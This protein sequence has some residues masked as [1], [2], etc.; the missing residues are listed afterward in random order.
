MDFV[1]VQRLQSIQM[2]K[3]EATEK[4]VSVARPCLFKFFYEF[5]VNSECAD[6]DHFLANFKIRT[7]SQ[8]ARVDHPSCDVK[9]LQGV[10]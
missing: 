7:C 9:D 10:V 3:F 1:T 4:I 6:V 2:L 8:N 5:P